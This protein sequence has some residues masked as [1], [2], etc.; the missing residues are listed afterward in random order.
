MRQE[1]KQDNLTLAGRSEAM[2]ETEELRRVMDAGRCKAVSKDVLKVD[3]PLGRWF[4]TGGTGIPL[5][6]LESRPDGTW[7]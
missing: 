3:G 7:Y 6:V 1:L 5:V 4:P 2:D